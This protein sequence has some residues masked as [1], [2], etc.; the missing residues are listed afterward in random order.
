M[1]TQLLATTSSP[2]RSIS[3]LQERLS[4]Y[5]ILPDDERYQSARDLRGFVNTRFPSLIV[6]AA[7]AEDVAE[8]VRFAR[9]HGLPFS[10]RGGGH[11]IAGY[12]LLDGAVAID[13]T[14]MT[15][16]TIDPDR[17]TARVQG[18]AKSRDL[19]LPAH[20]HGLALST[21][22]TGSVGLG[23]LVTGGGIGFFVRKY[24]LAADR[25]LSAR[26]VTADGEI[27]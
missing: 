17:Q 23:G 19:A 7:S 14:E 13:M 15:G 3:E 5:V 2:A 10:V 21:G 18:G 8:A 20:E 22:D 26:V 25:L 24:G 11:S 27:V 9:V 1:T 16:V 12:T 4:G 6:R